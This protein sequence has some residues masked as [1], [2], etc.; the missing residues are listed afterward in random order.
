[1]TQGPAPS[2][3]HRA[4]LDPREGEADARG[5]LDAPAPGIAP[6]VQVYRGFLD[7]TAAGA[8]R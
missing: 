3:A 4:E 5:T 2:I 6:F 8:S 1:M 7:G